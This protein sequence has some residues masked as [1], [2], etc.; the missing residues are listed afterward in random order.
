MS[1][2]TQRTS[3]G[4]I[5]MLAAFAVGCGP[6]RTVPV[7]RTWVVARTPPAFDPH[8]PADPVRDVLMRLTG[9]GLVRL[10]SLGD[11]QLDAAESLVVS[12]DGLELR[13]HL[14]ADLRFQDGSRCSS[15]TFARALE[16][17]LSRTDHGTVRWALA[18]LAGAAR[19]RPGRP[20]PELGIRTPDDRTLI[21]RLTTVDSL[22]PLRLAQPSIGTAWREDPTRPNWGIG[23]GDYAVRELEP[24]R[25]MLVR[26]S[27]ESDPRSGLSHDG[28]RPVDT[29]RVRFLLGAGRVR[30]ALR[31]GTADFVWPVPAELMQQPLPE[32]YRVERAT[33]RPSRRLLLVA[34]A[35][36]RPTWKLEA[37]QALAHGFARSEAL[38]RLQSWGRA[39]ATWLPDADVFDA[40]SY[41]RLA[42]QSWLNRGRFGRSLHAAMAFDADG[43]AALVAPAL[44]QEWAQ[45]GLDIELLPMRA[46]TFER[47]RLT[48]SRAALLLVEH[49]APLASAAAELAT[50]VTPAT[51]GAIGTFRS[52]W[53][54]H[55]FDRWLAPG[56]V[57]E[58]YEVQIAQDRLAE[59]RVV[60]PIATLDW[61]WIERPDRDLRGL[62]PHFG[63]LGGTP[64]ARAPKSSGLDAGSR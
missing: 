45:L 34:R 64:R 17:G 54:T 8:G 7:A 23:L 28:L 40:P 56:A 47:E 3:F 14:R 48:G 58:A 22:L 33:T 21:L 12:S 46:A 59:E 9:R 62:D 24:T 11:W 26:Q 15:Q 50:Y 49:Q 41:D 10:D 63:P 42:V 6:P 19:I 57:Q 53:R 1:N 60:A 36:V 43:P 13:F 39:E 31:A 27:S 51:G 61:L 18:S 4:I 30:A 35:D 2:S 25:W 5:G 37:R 16:Q 55:E 20:L 38:A 44:Q 52:G 32:G 29:L